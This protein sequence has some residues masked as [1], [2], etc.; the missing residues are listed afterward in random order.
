[1]FHLKHSMARDPAT[2]CLGGSTD[3][4]ERYKGFLLS[5]SNMHLK[6]RIVLKALSSETQSVCLML[7]DEETELR[8]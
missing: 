4:T 7:S 8:S 2:P 6:A 3:T 5:F 1:M